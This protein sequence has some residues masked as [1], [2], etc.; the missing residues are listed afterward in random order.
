MEI[1]N[2]ENT[3]I[4]GMPEDADPS[5]TKEPVDYS[6]ENNLK[7][8]DNL[9]IVTIKSINGSYCSSNGSYTIYAT[10]DKGTL[11]DTP[12]IEI[13][14]STAD[15]SSLCQ[16]IV[17]NEKSLR[18][19]CENKEEFSIF[20]IAY[21][22]MII[23]DSDG[24]VL[25]KLNNYTNQQQFACSISVNSVNI[26]NKVPNTGNDTKGGNE[27]TTQPTQP[28]QTTQPTQSTQPTQ[29]TQPINISTISFAHQ[30][31]ET[32]HFTFL[33]ISLRTTIISFNSSKSNSF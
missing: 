25:F 12:N 5:K 3:E 11:E 7:L 27:T 28:T 14:F 13:P 33:S 10:Y 20:P 9:P 19:D 17:G 26:Q 2:D 18:F 32:H 21:E 22:T 8:I 4:A 29:T 16:M 6:N 1:D 15:S 31:E 30:S 23:K 24:N